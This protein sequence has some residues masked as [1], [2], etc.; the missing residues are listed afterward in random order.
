IKW[1]FVKEGENV[2]TMKDSCFSTVLLK[3]T[4]VPTVDCENM[5][6]IT[7]NPTTTCDTLYKLVKPAGVFDDKCGESGLTYFYKTPSMAAFEEFKEGISEITVKLGDTTVTWKVK[8]EFN[9]SAEC[10]QK[11]HAIDTVVPVITCPADTTMEIT[12]ACDT[13]IQLIAPKMTDN[14]EIDKIYYKFNNGAENEYTAPFDFTFMKGDTLLKWYAKDKSGNVSDTCVRQYTVNDVAKPKID[15]PSDTAFKVRTKCDTL[16][17]ISAPAMSDNCAVVKVTYSF[18]GDE[19]EYTA[20]F[21]S[22]FKL[23]TTTIIWTA[24]DEANNFETC[25]RKYTVSD[26]T[27]INIICPTADSVVIDT[28]ENI[29]WAKILDLYSDD[30]KA[31]ATRIDCAN[32][33]EEKIDPV[34]YFKKEEDADY[35]SLTDAT[36]FEYNQVY[37]ILWEFTKSGENMETMIDSCFSKVILRDT[38]VPTVNCDLM[39]SVTLEPKESCDTLYTLLEPTGVF[40]DNCGA[41]ALTYYYQYGSAPFTEFEAGVSQITIENGDTTVFW[42]VKD[43]IGLASD[44]CAQKF[45]VVD[46]VKPLVVCPNDTTINVLADCQAAVQLNVAT[47][48]DFCGVESIQYSVDN[49]TFFKFVGSTLDTTLA[50]GSHTIYWRSEDVHGLISDVCEMTVDIKDTIV[51]TV[52]C[53]AD[54][55]IS[56]T[57]GCDTTVTFTPATAADNCDIKDIYYSFD[58]VTFSQV[59][60]EAITHKY[61]VGKDTVYWYSEDIYGNVSDTCKQSIAIQDE[62]KFDLECPAND[63]TKPFVVETCGNLDWKSLSDSL[64]DLNMYAT[65]SY[66]DCNTNTVTPIDSLVM[67]YSIKG[68][69]VWTEMTDDTT[70]LYNTDYIIR[71]IYTKSGEDLVDLSDTCE[72]LVVLKDTTNPVFDCATIN[73]DSLVQVLDG[74]CEVPFSEVI[75]NTYTATDNCDV[76]IDGV[77]SWTEN[78]ADTVKKG[79]TFE[80]GKL[81]ELK[82]I[83]QDKTGNQVTCDQKVMLNSNLKPLFDCD[84]L[85]KAV[86]DTVLQGVCEI[87][88][89]G[90]GVV[91]PFAL[92][93]CTK[94]TIWGTGVR[95]SG[96]AMNDK[97]YVGRDTITWTFESVYSTEVAICDQ[98]IFIQS[99]M[100]PVFDCDSLNKAVIDTVLQGVCEIDSTGLGVIAPFALDACTKDTIWG[101]GTRHSG[102]GMNDKYYVGRDTITWKFVSEYSTDTTFC[103]QFIFI[104]SDMKPV[105]DCDSLNKAVIDTVLQ[106]VCEIDST[107]LGVV[108][109]FALDACTKDTIWG[110]GTRHSGL[111]MNDKYYVGRDTITWKFVS[112]YSTDTTFCD[113]FIFIQSDMKPVFDCDSLN[114]AVIDT[115]LQGV[116]EIDST[117]LGVIAPFALDACTKDTIWG[118]GTRHSGLGMN[119]KYYVGRD[120]I[121]WKFVSEYSTDTTFC[122]QFIFIQ[123][124]MKPVFDCDSLN[125]AVIDTVLQGVCEIDSTGLGVIAPFALD[126]CTK[127]TIWGTG[128][129]HSGLG[130]N[131]KYYVGRDTI[132]WK[133]VSEYSTDTTFC[134]QFI[135]IQSDMKPLFDCDSLKNAPIDTVLSGI[136]EISAEDLKVKT[137]FAL[138]A[139]TKDTIWG[140][141]TRRSGNPVDG[142]YYVGRDTIDWKFESEYSTEVATC[143]QYVF[144]Q[145]DDKPNVDCDSLKNAP[146]EK[147]LEGVCEITAED[148]NVNIPFA[149]TCFNDTIWGQG[150]R[151]SGASMTDKYLVGRDTI[152]WMFGNENTVDTAY[153][154][155]YVF[156]Q[157]D[158]KPVFDCD[159]LKNDPIEKV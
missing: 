70:L 76:T 1:L 2:S 41:D 72:L 120:T 123:S 144:I 73:P 148:L 80:V 92:D 32:D 99:D 151:K 59:T 28:C 124:D 56:L 153:C 45:T 6:E 106:G 101:T 13:T 138:D 64:K 77:L 100:K 19:H 15:C 126:A 108:A 150:T 18:N 159:S 132:T 133:F 122:D 87:D 134:D 84:S 58:Y 152:V 118:T 94:D 116:C 119:D 88:S 5:P 62:R 147:V 135:F 71:W 48:S 74:V 142:I 60:D 30:Q 125:E 35:S 26:S 83:F 115:V 90:L 46:V 95:K 49:A 55:T 139:C 27:G 156:I 128:T 140:V 54:I 39:P 40:D 47:A 91:A 114:E 14:C 68:S 110:T 20:P 37:D 143:E 81:Y 38:S 96:L 102:L 82:W 21:D 109:P 129:R 105:F 53:P 42:M 7:L 61:P 3:D 137:P 113:Q 89:T 93:A 11:Y 17:K 9:E 117:G 43:A 63:D 141:G 78:I 51:P 36:I 4:S 145:N 57:K 69:N 10:E 154:E 8:D 104:Q 52:A 24:Y 33:V 157:S 65:A 103:D 130:M 16:M 97:Y 29:A 146:I 44:T 121:T 98:Y 111:G 155:Q 127:D 75:F 85:N 12:L 86:I 66:T 112:E 23:G 34:M 50:V 149:L 158:L 79:E 25:T 107:G 136:C 22:V 31:T 131:D 67:E